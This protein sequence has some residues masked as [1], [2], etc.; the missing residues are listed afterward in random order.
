MV[1]R[2]GPNLVSGF[3]LEEKTGPYISRR[4]FW[5]I[6]TMAL[7]IWALYMK[8]AYEIPDLQISI[9]DFEEPEKLTIINIDCENMLSPKEIKPREKTNLKEL[10]F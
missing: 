3:G 7:P 10:G 2:N 9:D 1:Y 8:R 6:T 5:P 4:L